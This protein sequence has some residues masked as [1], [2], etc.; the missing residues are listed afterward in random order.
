[1]FYNNNTP[2]AIEYLKYKAFLAHSDIEILEDTPSS[3][4]AAWYEDNK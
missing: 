2:E 3:L 4:R 1:M